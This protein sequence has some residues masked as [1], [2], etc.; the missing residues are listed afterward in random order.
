MRIAYISYEMP[1]ISGNG[2]IGTYIAQISRIMADRGHDV[3]VFCGVES[4]PGS[5]KIEKVT[6]HRVLGSRSQFGENVLSVFSDINQ[7]SPFDLIESQEYKA[8][9]YYVRIKYPKIPHIVKCH[10]PSFI[11]GRLNNKRDNW[12]NRIRY[13]IMGLVRF[14]LVKPYWTY[15]YLDDIEYQYAKSASIITSPSQSMAEWLEKEWHFKTGEIKVIHNP[16]H[17]QD[18]FLNL[19]PAQ[20]VRPFKILF[21]GRLE[22]RK[23]ILNLINAIPK[24]VKKYPD[25]I[26]IFAGEPLPSPDKSVLMDEFIKNR[27]LGFKNNLIFTGNLSYNQIPPVIEQSSICVFPSLWENFPNVCLEAMSAGRAVIG[28]SSGGMTEMITH[29]INGLL[30]EPNNSDQIADSI[31]ELI[32]DPSKIEEF[33]KRARQSV[34]N[35]FNRTLVGHRTEEIYVEAIGK[36][37]SDSQL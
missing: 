30:I 14:K 21:L 10:T 31:I 24:V 35:K 29:Q 34:I 27:L 28:S 2:G 37:K 3:H 19:K 33:G 9:G 18:A 16:F 13:I 15:Y 32:S 25:T 12:L 5:E 6:V 22:V 11:V 20:S 26:F 36:Q 7:Q 8:E 1:P 4:N 23:G 17:P